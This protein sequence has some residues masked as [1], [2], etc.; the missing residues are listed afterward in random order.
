[1]VFLFLACWNLQKPC[2]T[3]FLQA[4]LFHF[5][6]SVF[7]PIFCAHFWWTA[8]GHLRLW[9]RL[10]KLGLGSHILNKVEHII[11]WRKK[12]SEQR[13]FHNTFLYFTL[14]T[15]FSHSFSCVQQTFG[16]N[17][18]LLFLVWLMKWWK[19]G[20]QTWPKYSSVFLFFLHALGLIQKAPLKVEKKPT[21]FLI[22]FAK[23]ASCPRCSSAG[24]RNLFLFV[25]V[26]AASGHGSAR[27]RL[28]LC[29]LLVL[30][31]CS[32]GTWGLRKGFHWSCEFLCPSLRSCGTP[33]LSLTQK[34][35]LAFCGS[36]LCYLQ[37]PS[38]QFGFKKKWCDRKAGCRQIWQS[39]QVFQTITLLRTTTT[40]HVLLLKGLA[41]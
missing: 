5:I 28:C 35:L 7:V 14:P 2:S 8:F 23:I 6:S 1:M 31:M 10:R 38:L 26:I 9:S 25:C 19:T 13:W 29:V 18:N 22:L 4:Q 16:I 30:H 34:R 36:P 32:P 15:H 21:P 3:T 37:S 27:H 17:S 12:T 39:W 33:A 20:L 41:T 40:C 24:H 11:W